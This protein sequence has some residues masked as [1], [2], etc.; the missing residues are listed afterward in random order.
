MCVAT[1]ALYELKMKHEVATTRLNWAYHRPPT[2]V[3]EL[4]VT[5]KQRNMKRL[6]SEIVHE[7]VDIAMQCI[8]MRPTPDEVAAEVATWKV[9]RRHRLMDIARHI[10]DGVLRDCVDEII[11]EVGA[12]SFCR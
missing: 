9:E 7:M 12:V 8:L 5:A 2:Y 3:G 1:Q 4:A 6:C 11:A 10:A